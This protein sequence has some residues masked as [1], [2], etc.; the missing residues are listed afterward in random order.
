MVEV[1]VLDLIQFIAVVVLGIITPAKAPPV[2]LP[3]RKP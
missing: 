2:P 3:T 1:N